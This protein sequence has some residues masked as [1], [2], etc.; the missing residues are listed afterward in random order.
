MD[1]LSG[2][3]DN[4]LM[5]FNGYTP[6][7][8]AGIA[9]N[10]SEYLRNQLAT[11]MMGQQQID[12]N[13]A[14]IA[15]TGPSSGYGM[16]GGYPTFGE[17]QDLTGRSSFS[18]VPLGGG[19]N[20]S[21]S[22]ERGAD[23]PNLSVDPFS[24]TPQGQAD[25]ASF[26][27]LNGYQ[28]SD[29]YS[30]MGVFPGQPRSEDWQTTFSQMTAPA[31]QADPYEGGGGYDYNDPATYGGNGASMR[32]PQMPDMQRLLGYN[33]NA[34][35]PPAPSTYGAD[36]Y[37]TYGQPGAGGGGYGVPGGSDVPEWLRAYRQN[38]GREPDGSP[39]SGGL[40]ASGGD[41]SYL[42]A[43][44]PN[45]A[46]N[47]FGQINSGQ[48]GQY[49]PFGGSVRSLPGNNYSNPTVYEDPYGGL[50]RG[51]W[52]MNMGY[53]SFFNTDTPQGRADQEAFYRNNGQQGVIDPMGSSMTAPGAVQGTG[54]PSNADMDRMGYF[55]GQQ[56]FNAL[57]GNRF[58]ATG[59]PAMQDISQGA[60]Q[61]AINPLQDLQ[62]QI[63][64]FLNDPNGQYNPHTAPNVPNTLEPRDFTAGGSKGA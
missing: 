6:Q 3:S 5:G 43:G 45:N 49:D 60:Q 50:A 37:N 55:Q 57:M 21:G 29:P 36:P 58:N 18:G 28:Y 35:I 64:Y 10:N 38:F 46:Y 53:G 16:V 24:S 17:A 59:M 23:L 34:A 31:R 41:T 22:V 8:N 20:P 54:G 40:M 11:A 14:A 4:A 33:P 44:G 56:N 62:R 7:A 47:P 9:N 30:H 48:V 2:Y 25:R 19:G 42:G 61:Q 1:L 13:T 63:E 32:T 12:R 51:G 52:D 39:L 15:A 26:Q 27:A